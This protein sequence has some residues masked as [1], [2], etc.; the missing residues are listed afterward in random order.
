[1]AT[2]VG[3]TPYRPP[4]DQRGGS[5]VQDWLK[6]FSWASVA[7]RALTG[8]IKHSACWVVN[9]PDKP[10][11]YMLDAMSGVI[12]AA[13]YP[14]YTPAEG[15]RLVRQQF[16]NEELGRYHLQY[17]VPICRQME[18]DNLTY[19]KNDAASR[20]LQEATM[21]TLTD[22]FKSGQISLAHESTPPGADPGAGTGT[23][24]GGDP[25]H[26]W[27]VK[28]GIISPTPGGGAGGTLPQPEQA[29]ISTLVVIGVVVLAVGLMLASRKR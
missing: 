18:G 13:W 17:F 9:P 1:M 16:T 23:P 24:P 26:E 8:Q 14:S 15:K 27:L 3:G 20:A 12:A 25:I 2:P 11:E 4:A 5:S 7:W 19:N 29:G 10:L 28:H 22:L 21:R 6:Y